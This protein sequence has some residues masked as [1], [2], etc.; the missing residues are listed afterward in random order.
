MVLGQVRDDV[1][2]LRKLIQYLEDD[3]NGNFAPC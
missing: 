1:A 3:R 2:L